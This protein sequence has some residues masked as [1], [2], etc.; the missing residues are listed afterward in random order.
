MAY[1]SIYQMPQQVQLTLFSPTYLDLEIADG[2]G[3]MVEVTTTILLWTK[4]CYQLT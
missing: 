2:G 4:N 1:N 3:G